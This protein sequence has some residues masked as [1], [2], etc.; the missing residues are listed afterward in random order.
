MG[1]KWRFELKIRS[2]VTVHA[3]TSIKTVK[4]NDG[5]LIYPMRREQIWGVNDIR[6]RAN[7]F[8][9]LFQWLDQQLYRL[10]LG[11]VTDGSLSNAAYLIT[12]MNFL[13]TST[14]SEKN[15]GH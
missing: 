14:P 1:N 5:R 3:A 8:H 9:F 12:V 6:S 13:I 10:R 7:L 15:G 11:P 2:S 4:P